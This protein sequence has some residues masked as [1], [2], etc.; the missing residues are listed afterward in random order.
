MLNSNL[1]YYICLALFFLNVNHV[2]NAW[3]LNNMP[4]GIIVLSV[5]SRKIILKQQRNALN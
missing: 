4:E 3:F 2:V 5:R 1:F